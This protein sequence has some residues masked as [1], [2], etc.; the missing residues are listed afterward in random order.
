M[1]ASFGESLTRVPTNSEHFPFVIRGFNFEVQQ[2]NSFSLQRSE[3]FIAA[4]HAQESRSFGSEIFERKMAE[5]RKGGCAP[6]ERRGVKIGP[7]AINISPLMG[8]S[9]NNVLLHFQVESANDKWKIF[10][11]ECWVTA[12]KLAFKSIPL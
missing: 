10:P 9:D 12:Q 7:L 5:S 2:V 4:A 11:S 6:T 8:R 1:L 3:M